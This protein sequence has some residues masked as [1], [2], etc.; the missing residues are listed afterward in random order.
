MD[1]EYSYEDSGLDKF[2]S[3]SVDKLTTER[4]KNLSKPE[5]S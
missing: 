5:S 3:R 2:L 4:L 1:N